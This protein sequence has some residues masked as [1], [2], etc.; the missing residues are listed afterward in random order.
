MS[1]TGGTQ[2]DHIYST[3]RII[4][5]QNTT[6]TNSGSLIV[7][8]GMS[9]TKD[10]FIHNDLFIPS[11]SISTG[12]LKYT[13]SPIIGHT[14]RCFDIDGSS[15]WALTRDFRWNDEP[16]GISIHGYNIGMGVTNTTHNLSVSGT[17]QMFN[18]IYLEAPQT[19]IM[20]NGLK[21]NNNILIDTTGQTAIGT[22][23][24]EQ[25][26]LSGNLRVEG[27]I[28]NNNHT[29]NFPIASDILV[30]VS[31]TQRL[32]NKTIVNGT[33]DTQLDANNVK[34]INLATPTLTGDATNKLYVDNLILGID[35]KPS[36]LSKSVYD[37]P[38]SPAINDSYLV[39]IG[40]TGTFASHDN[41]IATYTASGWGYDFPT[42]GSAV[43]VEDEDAQWNYNGTVWVLFGTLVNHT[44]L[45]GLNL[46]DHLQYAL[47]KGRIGGQLLIGGTGGNMTILGSN[48]GG[49]IILG[50]T[51]GKV[52]IA[53]ANPTSNLHIKN[54][55]AVDTW[56]FDGSSGMTLGNNVIGI[57]TSSSGIRTLTI[58]GI[59]G[60]LGLG[61]TNPVEKFEINGGI[62]TKIKL[63]GNSLSGI[64]LNTTS[65]NTEIILGTTQ[66]SI[67]T[68]STIIIDT[69]NVSI[70]KNIAPDAALVIGGN[71][72]GT[73][74]GLTTPSILVGATGATIQIQDSMITSTQH[75]ILQP[76]GGFVAIGVTPAIEVL[77]VFGNI[78]LSGN[79]RKG[80]NSYILPVS[81]DTLIGTTT[82]NN[83]YNKS[84][85]DTSTNII[86][87]TTPT[88]KIHFD[89]SGGVP[90]TI[91]LAVTGA[92][93]NRLVLPDISDTIVTRNTSDILTNKQLSDSS[94]SIVNVNNNTKRI[95]FD[96]SGN[97]AN[98]TVTLNSIGT[99]NRILTLPDITDTLVSKNS[100]DILT[101]KTIVTPSISGVCNFSS[102]IIVQGNIY[103]FGS[104]AILESNILTVG[105]NLIKLAS[106]NT[107]SDVID[108]GIYSVYSNLGTTSYTGIFRDATDARYKFF[109][110]LTIEPSTVIGITTGSFTFANVQMNKLYADF[111]ESSN[112]TP[113][114]INTNVKVTNTGL[115]GIGGVVPMS[116]FQVAGSINF[117]NTIGI[118]TAG[119][120]IGTAPVAN[121]DILGNVNISNSSVVNSL[122]GTANIS[123]TTITG[124]GSV[125]TK[126][127]QIGDFIIVG[128][129]L[130]K[131]VVSSVDSDSQLTVVSSLSTVSGV[132]LSL[133]RSPLRSNNVIIN[134]SGYVGFG[135]RLPTF[136]FELNANTQS[137][138]QRINNNQSTI[139]I[140]NNTG[141]GININ[142][143]SLINNSYSIITSSVSGTLFK[144]QTDGK[145][146]IGN[147]NPSELLD[148]T[149]GIAGQGAQIG[150]AMIGVWLGSNAY[151][152]IIHSNLKATSTAYAIKQHSS[153]DTTIN[154]ANTKSI[155]LA[156]QDSNKVVVDPSGNVGIGVLSG[157]DAKLH[158]AGAAHVTGNMFVDGSV[159]ISG[160]SAELN[161]STLTIDDTIIKLGDG[162]MT[163]VLDIG[164]YGQYNNNGIK[165][166]GIFRDADDGIFKIFKDLEVE[167][168]ITSIQT[169]G[170]GYTDA[171]LRIG[172]L[173][174]SGG[175]RNIP[176]T[177]SV[178]T[179]LTSNH[180][181][182][183]VNGTIDIILPQG[184]TVDT[185]TGHSFKIVNVGTG[186]VRI[187]TSGSDLIDG[188]VTNY[189]MYNKFDRVSF[190]N[191]GSDPSNSN[192]GIWLIN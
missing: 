49:N 94:L 72:L 34:I 188:T 186:V 27:T 69:R 103:Q 3:L 74:F 110:S 24:S 79:L 50:T 154:A 122:T 152:S 99:T 176:T 93:S 35:W 148:I 141:E 83:I 41:A 165:F 86:N 163:D 179:T 170:L 42:K 126:E 64:S 173:I 84:L 167:P 60:L 80:S 37:A 123:G 156:I 134:T 17:V 139:H 143:G 46:D 98:T 180:N 87:E 120:G 48:T 129:S 14:L 125:F 187:I 16:N 145:V 153:G 162:N 66:L 31:N 29:F 23:I 55:F 25:L 7:E 30:G 57:D 2:V 40:A 6:G 21:L 45:L 36:V 106:S 169:N 85:V 71:N 15:E 63:S 192:I 124:I 117:N 32:S 91:T 115:V 96:I 190:Q 116:N 13:R 135:T 161:V 174:S 108:A 101:N 43:L 33:L 88:R 114:T 73:H 9:I 65:A 147:G 12:D 166:A 158:V 54:N 95:T 121:L 18:N 191:I 75:L 11:G 112:N 113:L 28:K 44:N 164:I 183:L 144:V 105:D 81:S 151:T 78:R 90:A 92:G 10:L 20:Y 127:V 51:N 171:D 150:N 137:W 184:R 131:T 38:V 157:L 62:M 100:I 82:T 26:N 177:V 189:Y 109:D 89:V 107:A 118:T 8:G 97:T 142:T 111:V 58:T 52:G 76:T 140:G 119:I 132:S 19:T 138:A 61:V 168:G 182:V 185:F 67:T 68:T 130:E 59:S 104:V 159:Y 4:G 53:T 1:A 155:Y 160:T 172:N 22:S 149:T 39:P 70:G 136:P 146:G 178:G 77:D 181:T 56:V 102:D 47:L 175:V 133:R 5:T 128:G